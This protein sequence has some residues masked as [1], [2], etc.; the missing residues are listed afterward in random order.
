MTKKN[1][2]SCKKR[3]ATFN[4]KMQFQL[5]DGFG[6]PVENTQFWTELLINKKDNIIIIQFPLINFQVGPTGATDDFNP[7]PGGTLV[8]SDGYLPEDIRTADSVYRSYMVPS[9]NGVS[10]AFTYANST[11]P[12]PITGYVIGLTFYGGI[13]ISGAGQYLNLIPP[14]PQVMMPTTITYI[15]VKQKTI[16]KNFIVGAGFSNMTQFVDGRASSDAY[17]DSHVNDA[18]GGISAWAWTD[19]SMVLDKTNGVMNLMV[20]IND[21]APVQLTDFPPEVMAWDT[22]VAI[23][24]Q[25]KNNIVVSYEVLDHTGP[26]TMGKTC[27]AISFTGGATWPIA[28]TYTNS[29]LYNGPTNIQPTGIPSRAGDNRGVASDKF[30]NIWYGTTNAFDDLGTGIDQPTFWISIDG[31]ITFEIA[32]TAPYPLNPGDNYDIPQFCFGGD[33]FGNY[34]LWWVADY[35][36]SVGDIIPVVG[37][38]QINGLGIIGPA[39]PAEFLYSLANTQYLPSLSASA[40]GR[41]WCQSYTGTYSLYSSGVIRFKSPGPPDSNYAGSW[42][43]AFTFNPSAFGY[44]FFTSYPIVNSY[45][46]GYFNSVQTTIYDETRSALYA[47]RA[48][49]AP[50]WSQNMR[51]YLVISRDNGQTWTDPLYISNCDF[52]NRGFPS[53]ALDTVTGDLVFGWYDGRNDKNELSV[54]YF[55]AKLSA[56]RLDKIIKCIPLSNPIFELGPA[57]TPIP[58]DSNVRQQHI[59]S[60]IQRRKPRFQK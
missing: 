13:T 5:Y 23:N 32:Y 35:S 26:V 43:T 16:C 48:Q 9:N 4:H 30:G 1:S 57:T 15:H 36:N 18:F 42:Q 27:I 29:P 46:G 54:Q 28:Y 19:N 44:N 49:T 8:T 21:M 45:P 55:G 39:T 51:I 47:L 14:G 53:M 38:V 2:T 59:K 60:R 52:A 31:G 37:F 12:N 33:G 50:D 40:D 11:F 56:R 3:C 25:N 17:R 22:A 58:I 34:G 7:V 20:K 41:V 24:R 6:I 10:S